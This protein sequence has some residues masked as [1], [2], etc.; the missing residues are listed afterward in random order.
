MDRAER[1]QYAADRA[2]TAEDQTAEVAE[3]MNDLRDV[4]RSTLTINDAIDLDSLRS[5]ETTTR[6]EVPV[7]L[8][9][10]NAPPKKD[11]FL[12][13]VRPVAFFERLLSK[14]ERYERELREAAARYE[15]A[16]ARYMATEQER[17]AKIAELEAQHDAKNQKVLAEIRQR[18][19][20]VEELK[21]DYRKYK[22]LSI[23]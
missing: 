2:A 21:H 15:Q 20:D 10:S 5:E 6:F 19:A 17:V 18:N 11:D 9:T 4:L 23:D 12:L 16:H 13:P 7:E 1:Q 8:R 14:R 3:T 22:S